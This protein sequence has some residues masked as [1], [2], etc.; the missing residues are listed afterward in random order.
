[1]P[2]IV[3]VDDVNNNLNSYLIIDV[4]TNE[5]Y[6]SGHIP[7][8]INV[9][10]DSL[11]E[12]VNST[13]NILQYPKVV[14]VSS[15]GQASAYYTCLLRLYGISNV[16]SLNFGMAL[17]NKAFSDIWIENI[18]DNK[19]SDI[20]DDTSHF[21]IEANMKLP[22]NLINLHQGNKKEIINNLISKIIKEGFI[23]NQNYVNLNPDQDTILFNGED[24]VNFYTIFYGPLLLYLP[25]FKSEYPT[26]HLSYAYF[27]NTES[28]RS[29]TFLQTLPSNKR[30]VIYSI[31]GQTSAFIA[32]FLQVLGYDAKTLLYG[33]NY[34]CH[35]RLIID[36]NSFSPYV[37]LTDN[38]RDYS[39]VIGSS[40]K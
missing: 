31:S 13:K 8:A 25:I 9:Q 35:S 29:S 26:G 5:E 32:A 19:T 28:F 33:A 12:F 30:I 15:D 11:I 36:L 2:S 3:D 27:Y 7:G 20:L 21:P 37:F 6:I 17:W 10:N 39:F 4:R 1:M 24:L 14:I 18:H 38:I 34:Y 16:Y 40:P 22:D 23:D